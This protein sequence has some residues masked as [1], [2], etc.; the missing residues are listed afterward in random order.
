[1]IDGEM[2]QDS[3]IAG[4]FEGAFFPPHI[5]DDGGMRVQHAFWKTGRPRGEHEQHLVLRRS[6]RLPL[7]QGAIQFGAAV[8]K[9]R[10]KIH[11]TSRCLSDDQ[12]F[13]DAGQLETVGQGAFHQVY[14]FVFVLGK[15]H[16]RA[17]VAQDAVGFLDGKT[18]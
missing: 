9:K 2:E 3:R 16:R 4:H 17:A 18:W 5:A 12:D 10:F 13:P 8:G 15:Q 1:M 14:A 7:F 11:H 6:L